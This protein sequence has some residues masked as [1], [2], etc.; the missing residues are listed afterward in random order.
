MM[1]FLGAGSRSA[2]RRAGRRAGRSLTTGGI[3][4]PEI[5]RPAAKTTARRLA[6]PARPG[7][8]RCVIILKPNMEILPSLAIRL[9]IM[10]RQGQELG[11]T[12]NALA[13]ANH[14][15]LHPS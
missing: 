9:A 1:R 5:A 13:H 12:R 11:C 15:R 10:T 14:P 6:T 8:T 7:A 3:A 2:A 4:Q